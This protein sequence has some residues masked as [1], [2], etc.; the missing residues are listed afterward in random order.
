MQH[1]CV[2]CGAH[3]YGYRVEMDG[4]GTAQEWLGE[5]EQKKEGGTFLHQLYGFCTQIAVFTKLDT[6]NAQPP[7]YI[8]TYQLLHVIF[9]EI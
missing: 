7:W 1:Q 2:Q 4:V 8:V 3:S 6:G 9:L 5:H